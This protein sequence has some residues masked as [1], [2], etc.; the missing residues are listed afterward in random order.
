[1]RAALSRQQLAFGFLR[2]KFILLAGEI[3]ATPESGAV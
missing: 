3:R 2:I 1:M